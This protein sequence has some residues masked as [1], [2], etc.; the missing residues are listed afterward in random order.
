M[1]LGSKGVAESAP[2]APAHHGRNLGPA[3]EALGQQT[4]GPGFLGSQTLHP[5]SRQRRMSSSI[6]DR[7]RATRRR[8]AS[9]PRGRGRVFCSQAPLAAVVAA[10]SQQEGQSGVASAGT[11]LETH[12]HCPR[13]WKPPT[14]GASDGGGA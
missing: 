2:P 3:P 1:I 13:G 8:A 7:G 6:G 9:E 14:T 12:T 11:F 5:R 4:A 10:A